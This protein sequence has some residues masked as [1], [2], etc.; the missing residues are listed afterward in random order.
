MVTAFVLRV[1]INI[2]YNGIK[3]VKIY[4]SLPEHC[5]SW[6]YIHRNAVTYNTEVYSHCT[7]YCNNKYFV[8]CST[9][10]ISMHPQCHT[11]YCT[12][13]YYI[14]CFELNFI[15]IF[16]HTNEWHHMSLTALIAPPL[17]TWTFPGLQIIVPHAALRHTCNF[18]TKS[19]KDGTILKLNFT[20]DILCFVLSTWL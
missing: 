18:N 4:P 10:C 2:C 9:L 19:E 11:A 7:L 14:C 6:L 5:E 1:I 15:T 8:I 12:I 3:Y 13:L 16:M 20:Q 17:F